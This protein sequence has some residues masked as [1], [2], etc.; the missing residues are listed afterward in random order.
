MSG[1]MNLAMGTCV[2]AVLGAAGA[3]HF[4]ETGRAQSASPQTAAARPAPPQPASAS[5]M[6]LFAD[7]RGHFS[8][9]IQVNGALIAV[10][11]DTGA[12]MVALSHEDAEKANIR[13]G[14]NARKGTANTANGQVQFTLVR[15]NEVRLGSLTVRDVEA[16]IMPRGAMNG[17]LLGMSFLKR[18]SKFEVEN[19]RLLLTQ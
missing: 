14:P 9:N 4:F 8:S 7:R 6:A 10:L 18:L 2:A 1:V 15:L 3:A 13:P 19:G 16:G 5:T 12:S 11:V 17:T